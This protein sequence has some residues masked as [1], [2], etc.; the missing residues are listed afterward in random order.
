[1]NDA[2][3]YQIK[4]EGCGVSRTQ[5]NTINRTNNRCPFC[6]SPSLRQRELDPSLIDA[7]LIIP[8]T[9]NRNRAE[10]LMKLALPKLA[11]RRNFDPKATINLRAVAYIP[12]WHMDI[13]VDP[14]G[15]GPTKPHTILQRH[16]AIHPPLAKFVIPVI[17]RRLDGFVPFSS[18]YIQDVPLVIPD[19]TYERIA[20]R[21]L[22]G[23]QDDLQTASLPATRETGLIGEVGMVTTLRLIPIWIFTLIAPKKIHHVLV[24]G[25]IGDLHPIQPRDR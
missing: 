8:L 14:D 13:A 5:Y 21:V 7:D 16:P 24:D 3:K 23:V 4:C 19:I 20:K 18:Q 1:M 25:V 10:K 22:L 17:N 11:E 9:I 2:I 6:G 12:V 15:I